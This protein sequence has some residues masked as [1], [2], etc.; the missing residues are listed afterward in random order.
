[1]GY[2]LDCD[3]V[4]I[5]V[6]VTIVQ[7]GAGHICVAGKRNRRSPL[8]NCKKMAR[9]LWIDTTGPALLRLSQTCKHTNEDPKDS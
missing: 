9:T 4:I 1:M 7:R 2:T 3:G 8:I 6:W 5:D